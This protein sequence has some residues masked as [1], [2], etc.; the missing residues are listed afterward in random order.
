MAKKAKISKK[1]P[2]KPEPQAKSIMAL[3]KGES[4]VVDVPMRV[5]RCGGFMGHTNPDGQYLEFNEGDL[6][7]QFIDHYKWRAKLA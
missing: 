4:M 3:G 6:M 5:T 2:A 7:A 1:A